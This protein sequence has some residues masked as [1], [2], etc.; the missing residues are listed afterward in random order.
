MQFGMDD[1]GFF[2]DW[3]TS[4]VVWIE[5]IGFV[6]ILGIVELFLGHPRNRNSTNHGTLEL[7]KFEVPNCTILG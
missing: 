4:F 1:A 3:I 6:W 5:L 2:P 7:I